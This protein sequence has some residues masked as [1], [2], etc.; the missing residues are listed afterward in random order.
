MEFFQKYLVNTIVLLLVDYF[1]IKSLLRPLLSQYKEAKN[2]I[3]HGCHVTGRIVGYEKKE[4]LDGHTQ[5]SPNI[6][7]MDI[8]GKKHVYHS[9]ERSYEKYKVG[10][11]VDVYFKCSDSSVFIIGGDDILVKKI[12]IIIVAIA[13]CLTVNLGM[14]YYV[15][16]N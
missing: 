10:E 16:A 9:D 3:D 14:L 8:D 13:I 6:E 5:Y 15:F 2:L 7:F 4:D 12:I 1:Y 11:D